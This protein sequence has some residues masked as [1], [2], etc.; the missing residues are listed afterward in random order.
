G[1]TTSS[2]RT[3]ASASS[4]S[5][6]RIRSPRPASRSPSPRRSPACR[7]RWPRPST[8]WP[9]PRAT[10]PHPSWPASLPAVTVPSSSTAVPLTKP[11]TGRPRGRNPA[12][13]GT[14]L[15]ASLPDHELVPTASETRAGPHRGTLLALA[16][17]LGFDVLFLVGAAPR[18]AAPFGDSH[19]G[20]NG[21]AWAL[22]SRAIRH[23]GII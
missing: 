21:A 22:A 18:I 11:R 19:D 3:S 14:T 15:R 2:P 20:R 17:L 5:R 9:S 12:A 6:T 7:P 1:P 16:I 13:D 4:S 23:Q 10:G 8:R